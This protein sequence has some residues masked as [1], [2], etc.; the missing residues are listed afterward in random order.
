MS[1]DRLVEEIRRRGE[2]ELANIR[3]T[4]ESDRIRLASERDRRLAEIREQSRR[5][6]AAEIARE[7]AQ[8]IAAADLLARKAIY[9]ARERR[10]QQSIG[11]VRELLRSYTSDPA[12]PKV[13]EKMI[14]QVTR[15]LGSDARIRG[16]PEDAAT[17]SSLAGSRFDP[18]PAPILGGIV[19]V[20]SDGRRRLNLSF[21]ELLRL[22]EDR[23]R[24][25]LA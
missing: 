12:Y 10:L 13:L 23:V 11:E 21:D 2:S 9:E 20:S 16:R 24:E 17:L 15:D 8:R 14:A 5:S 22:R 3:S 6:T 1:L 19:G 25:L 7:R 4:A 18:V